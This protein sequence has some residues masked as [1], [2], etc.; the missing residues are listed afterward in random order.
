MN[1][2]YYDLDNDS[3]VSDFVR[4]SAKKWSEPIPQE[5]VVDRRLNEYQRYLVR[6]ILFIIFCT[7]LMFVCV[8]ITVTIGAYD[9]GFWE[10][11]RIIWNHVLGILPSDPLDVT[12]DF[13]VVQLRMPSV[14]TAVVAGAGLAVCGVAMQS[15]LKNPL[16]DPYTTGVSSG[17]GFGASLA[18]ALDMTLISGEYSLVVNA[19]VFALIP[20]AAMIFVAKI[21][22]ASPTT[23]IM[24][25]I[26]IMYIFNACTTMVKFWADDETISA[27]FRWQVGS[28]SGT[29]WE[30]IAIM[31]VVV[32]AGTIAIWILSRKINLLATGDENAKAMG[33]NAEQLRIICLVIVALISAGIVSFT[34]LIGFIGL[35]APHIVRL[36][37]GA[38]N[39]YLVPASAAFGAALL[40]FAYA[41]SIWLIEP[42]TLQ[43]GV[44]TAFLGGPMFLWLIVRNKGSAW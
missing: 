21:R 18:L 41:V 3:H 29:T 28:V 8:G 36:F 14:V 27:I 19:F 2:R 40:V 20:T 1:G 34:G 39:R 13:V 22:N 17:A 11:Y 37:I 26:A 5:D 23:M 6:K 43:V 30:Q 35:V 32:I 15:T 44:V 9:I 10:T 12:K 7:V 42:I 33:I 16:A 4:R 38:D 25:G 24:A 31:A